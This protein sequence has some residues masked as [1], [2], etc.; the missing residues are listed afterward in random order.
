LDFY[1]A[2]GDRFSGLE[3]NPYHGEEC[4]M[5]GVSRS[6]VR[7]RGDAPDV[8]TIGRAT[9]SGL[10][11]GE[12]EVAPGKWRYRI[13]RT[14][15]L[16]YGFVATSLTIGRRYRILWTETVDAIIARREADAEGVEGD[17]YLDA[18]SEA[19]LEF[20]TANTKAFYTEFLATKVAHGLFSPG[21]TIEGND[22]KFPDYPTT[23]DFSRA[24]EVAGGVATTGVIPIEGEGR[25]ADP[26]EPASFFCA[27]GGW[28]GPPEGLTLTP[29][30][31]A[32]QLT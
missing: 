28:G 20:K 24:V 21:L 26:I 29:Q 19:F 31:V 13:Y 27:D 18:G 4:A 11:S 9:L 23:S 8:E 32:P 10:D 5:L 14:F 17:D 16:H 2:E 7:G 12:E 25:A 15:P 6:I 3:G 30:Y 1:F 22:Y